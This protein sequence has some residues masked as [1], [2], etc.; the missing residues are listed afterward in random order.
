[1]K[2]YVVE[3]RSALSQNHYIRKAN[4]IGYWF[5]FTL[6]K[7]NRYRRKFD[8]NFCL[9]LFGSETGDD[10]YIIP[11]TKAK[12]LFIEQL[13][14]HRGRWVGYINNNLMRL[15]RGCNSISVSAFYNAFEL[16]ET[17]QDEAD[18]SDIFQ[19]VGDIDLVALRNKIR[20]FNKQY[21][22]VAPHKKRIVSE[23]IARPGGITDYLKKLRSYTCQLCHQKGFLQRNQTP[24]IETHH[25]IELHKLIPGSYC[26]DNIVVVC[27]TCHK[28]LHY[29]TI[30]YKVIDRETVIVNINGMKHEFKRNTVTCESGAV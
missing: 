16:L 30:S 5:D 26:S 27:P 2:S 6:N 29:A 18:D 12:G 22:H 10:A 23:Q 15:N 19:L 11:F 17:N 3:N 25:I 14:D 1:M 20:L 21:S 28:K 4:A 24:Y 13:L 8:D 7:L 9:I